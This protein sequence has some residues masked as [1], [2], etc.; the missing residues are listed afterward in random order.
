[1]RTIS[2][3]IAVFALLTMI[4]IGVSAQDE[5]TIT[6]DEPVSGELDSQTYEQFYT[7][8]GNEGDTI[9]I[10]MTATSE[11]P[12]LD[13]YLFL[14]D[15]DGNE[16][17]F[18]DD[19]AGNL[20]SL[21]GPYTLEAD[22]V[23]TIVATRYQQENGG[24]EGTYEVTLTIATT[25]TI[26]SGDVTEF[27]V[28]EATSPIIFEYE[29]EEDGLYRLNYHLIDGVGGSDVTV[30]N[31]ENNFITGVSV[32][33]TNSSNFTTLNLEQGETISLFARYYPY[34]DVETD[35]PEVTVAISIVSVEAEPLELELG[36]PLELSGVLE[37][38]ESVAYYTFEAETGQTL[39]ITGGAPDGGE[40]EIYAILPAGYSTF[41]GNSSYPTSEDGDVL[42]P[43]QIITQTG[44]YILVIHRAN[45]YVN[46]VDDDEPVAYELGLTLSSTPELVSGEAVEGQLD[47]GAQI[48]EDAYLYNGEEGETITITLEGVSEDYAVSFSISLDVQDNFENSYYANF[49][50]SASGTVVYTVT[51]PADGTYIVRIYD[52]NYYGQDE[53]GE[54]RLLLESDK[55]SE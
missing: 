16:L 46:Q 53:S 28:D 47:H 14:L 15:E 55:D 44:E 41:Y 11:E 26:E 6:F 3:L 31:D 20:N 37:D 13:S 18:D 24:S 25:E 34:R 2:K 54:Y 22:G 21:L 29:A 30:R 32:D 19:S 35:E 40:F 9:I 4:A 45:I 17:A 48:Y 42:V 39:E 27:V 52:G 5:D 23:Y 49:N 12:R 38:S 10:R 7:F 36:E 51:L 1:M 50:S 43:S 8:E 33:E